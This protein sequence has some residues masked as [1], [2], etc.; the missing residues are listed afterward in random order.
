MWTWLLKGTLP[1]NHRKSF[2][3]STKS[4][5]NYSLDF[6]KFPDSIDPVNAF[7][8]HNIGNLIRYV[9]SQGVRT[10]LHHSQL[11]WNY[12]LQRNKIYNSS[13]LFK[14]FLSHIKTFV[15]EVYVLV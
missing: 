4:L 15:N 9:H 11:Y 1:V 12:F 5:D 3:I 7:Q 13:V 14:H 8:I 2:F 6:S 10:N